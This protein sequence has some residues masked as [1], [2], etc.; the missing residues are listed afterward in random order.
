MSKS[1]SNEELE[2]SS[3]L[4]G[5]NA[6][7]V[8]AQVHDA[9]GDRSVRARREFFRISPER[10][11]AALRL[12][13]T[14]NVTPGTPVVTNEATSADV[15]HDLQEA[16]ERRARFNFPMVDIPVGASL[17]FT[18]DSSVIGVQLTAATCLP[19]RP[20]ARSALCLSRL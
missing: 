3:F 5:T 11:V 1:S 17:T 14:E 18:R 8:E 4:F 16:R 9:F 2:R 12:A 19:V 6:A 20:A 15:Q 7:F 13:E 10:V